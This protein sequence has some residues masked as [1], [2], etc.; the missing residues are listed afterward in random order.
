MPPTAQLLSEYKLQELPPGRLG[1]PPPAPAAADIARL[2]A[3]ADAI[4][5]LLQYRHQGFLPNRRQQRMAGLAAVE[6]AQAVKHLVIYPTNLPDCLTH[7][8]TCLSLSEVVM[9][10]RCMQTWDALT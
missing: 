4:G 8:P 5:K 9:T 10:C 1:Q 7:P 2:I 6:I 3:A